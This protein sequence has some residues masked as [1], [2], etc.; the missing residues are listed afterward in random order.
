MVLKSNC[1]FVLFSFLKDRNISTY[2][3]SFT[4]F[5]A[6]QSDDVKFM[7]DFAA[8]IFFKKKC[9]YKYKHIH[10]KYVNI[11]M[12]NIYVTINRL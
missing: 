2:R 10:N 11:N 9:R 12:L 7:K 4:L 6:S 5:K 3:S 1:F 8:N